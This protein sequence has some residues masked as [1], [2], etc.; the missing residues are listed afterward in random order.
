M[1]FYA[2]NDFQVDYNSTSVRKAGSLPR[3]IKRLRIVFW[4]S[5]ILCST[6]TASPAWQ[7]NKYDNFVFFFFLQ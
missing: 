3:L 6:R 1:P 2:V 4:I 7:A 5:A